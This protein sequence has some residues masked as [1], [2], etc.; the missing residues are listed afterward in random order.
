VIK[1]R[2][3]LCLEC[4]NNVD[5]KGLG[6]CPI[7]NNR[8]KNT[9]LQNI[10]IETSKEF[11]ID[12][13]ASLYKCDRNVNELLNNYI[14]KRCH[15]SAY[16][17]LCACNLKELGEFE[18][19]NELEYVAQKKLEIETKVLELLGTS[20]NV[21]LNMSNLISKALE[22]VKIAQ[23]IEKLAKTSNN[24]EIVRE[25]SKI[26]ID[27]SNNLFILNLISSKIVEKNI[28]QN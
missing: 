22:D 25:I 3:Y 24:D 4:G 23:E 7:C 26:I 14:K 12:N 20:M 2:R 27:E 15:S 6:I 8:N 18:L 13:K 11:S 19:S 28:I 17:K 16:L 9:L 21:R 10:D 5:L 1:L